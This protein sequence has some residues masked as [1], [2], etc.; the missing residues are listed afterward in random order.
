[1]INIA[2]V[3]LAQPLE[4]I[5]DEL[6]RSFGVSM[7]VTYKGSKAC[8]AAIAIVVFAP[9]HAPLLAA[10]RAKLHDIIGS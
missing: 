3:S 7:A 9:L 6:G 4:T 10:H 8:L 1:M 5:A 2:S